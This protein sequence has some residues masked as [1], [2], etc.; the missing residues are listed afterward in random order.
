MPKSG[1]SKQRLL[2]TLHR[3][4]GVVIAVLVIWLAISGVMLNHSAGLRLNDRHIGADLAEA[5]YGLQPESVESGFLV[6]EQWLATA[7]NQL[8]VGSQ[9][10]ASG[11]QNLLAAVALPPMFIV[12]VDSKSV[13]LLL[14]SGELVERLYGADLPVQQIATA[15]SSDEFLLLWSESGRCFRSTNSELV[16]WQPCSEAQRQTAPVTQATLPAE[17]RQAI[18]KQ[19]GGAKIS[20]QQLLLD[21]HSGKAVGWLGRLLADSS[22]ILLILLAVTGLVMAS[23]RRKL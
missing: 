4:T 8:F 11:Y 6:A 15:S 21:L 20:W 18:E 10:V 16:A 7:E 19:L 5:I 12:A 2:R 23:R 9:P 22:A 17:Q 13:T 3:R 1:A 14:S